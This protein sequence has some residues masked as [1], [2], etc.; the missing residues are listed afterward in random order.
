MKSVLP[1]MGLLLILNCAATAGP[2]TESTDVFLEHTGGYFGYRIPAIETTPD[3]S[4]L[5]FAEARKYSL[6]DPGYGNQDIDLVFR[7]STDGGKSW[8][9]M[10]VIDDPGERWSAAN[11]ATVV[12]RSNGR[13][14]LLYLRCKPGRNTD[15]ARPGT[16]DSQVLARTSDDNG[17]NWSAAG[18]LDRGF[19]RL[20]GSA[21][22]RQRRRTGG[23]DPGSSRPARGGL[24]E[25]RTVRQ[26]CSI[27]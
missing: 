5:A 23:N 27:H 24:L 12:D 14:W 8:S 16:D 22:A 15:T 7:R 19:T 18:R 25:I 20:R 13:V 4:L 26:F 1:A 2:P 6:E 17:L 10:K 9:P 21:M 11:P 3:G